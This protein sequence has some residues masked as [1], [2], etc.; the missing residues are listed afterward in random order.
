MSHKQISY[1]VR[2]KTFFCL[3]SRQDWVNMSM[4]CLR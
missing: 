1:L 2:M 3:F 4:N